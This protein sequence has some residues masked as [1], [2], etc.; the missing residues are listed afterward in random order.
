MVVMVLSVRGYRFT[1]PIPIP[2]FWIIPQPSV[3][4]VIYTIHV[5]SSCSVLNIEKFI[6]DNCISLFS[7]VD[8]SSDFGALYIA[9]ETRAD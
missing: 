1:I 4:L 6:Y 9:K 2:G 5:L 7:L 8:L 3:D